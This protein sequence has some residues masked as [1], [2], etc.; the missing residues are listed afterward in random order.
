MHTHSQTHTHTHTLTNTQAHTSTLTQAH[1]YAH[2]H[3]TQTHT[4]TQLG[5]TNACLR[6]VKSSVNS[7]ML[8]G[9]LGGTQVCNLA[10][11]GRT[12]LGPARFDDRLHSLTSLLRF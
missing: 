2:T 7:L 11:G 4:H 12:T 8:S 5:H 9:P 1:T 3:T 10:S 6:M